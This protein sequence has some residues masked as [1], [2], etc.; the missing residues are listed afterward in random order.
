MRDPQRRGLF[1]R[2]HLIWFARGLQAGPQRLDAGE[3]VQVE[4]HSEAELDALA[5]ANRL[6]DVKTRVGLHQLQRWRMGAWPLHW[7]GVEAAR[8]WAA[9]QGHRAVEPRPAR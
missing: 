4:T 2:K 1:H 9:T 8:A 7:M 3:F 5:A 6:P